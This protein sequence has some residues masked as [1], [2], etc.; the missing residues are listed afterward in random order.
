[1]K[2]QC[3]K[4]GLIFDDEFWSTYCKGLATTG[5]QYIL[6]YEARREMIAK[7]EELKADND[8]GATP[9]PT[10]KQ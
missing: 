1:M 2:R 5:H 10:P 8:E 7:T 4:C 3:E 6:P 9:W